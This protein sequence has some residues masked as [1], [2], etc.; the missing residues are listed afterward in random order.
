M[1]NGTERHRILVIDD[2]SIVAAAL[3]RLLEHDYDVETVDSAEE[4]LRLLQTTNF[5]VVVTDL[6]MRG[7]SGLE[8]IKS[9]HPEKPQL[10]VILLTGHHTTD[11]AI[12]AIKFGAFDYVLKPISSQREIQEFLALIAKAVATSVAA[13]KPAGESERKPPVNT[14]VGRSRQMQQVY[15]EI[16]RVAARPVLVLIRGET[17][18][19]KELVARA[20]HRYS[21]R[22]EQPFVIVNCV[23]IPEALL[24]S[25]LFGHEQGAFTGAQNTR[26][27]K[28]EQADKGTLFLDEIGD[29]SLA[30]QAK[31]LRVMQ[32]SAIRR[33][34]G[35][36]LIR[37]DVRVVAATHRDL[38]QA[39]AAKTFREDLYYRL[40]DASIRLPSLRERREDI[41]PLVQHFLHLHPGT[42]AAGQTTI[43]GDALR[44]LQY[45]SW[46][47]NV[48][49]L[50]N[51]VNQAA[52]MARGYAI[53][54]EIVRA[55]ME[56]A[57]LS[58]REP[59]Q[60]LDS[61][62]AELL[63]NA[64]SEGSTNVQ[65]ALTEWV[66]RELY[67]QAMR[68]AGEDQSQVARWL[69]V[70]RPTVRERL[71]HYGLHPGGQRV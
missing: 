14:M 45:H 6:Q 18:T 16:G 37:V 42:P 24:E 17:G 54:S 8:F 62:V 3:R 44:I 32:E 36:E 1:N 52:V 12:E 13:I 64:V 50:K 11:H 71:L 47:G 7:K 70:S 22:A 43:N 2:D 49:E 60:F 31:L 66:E 33:V 23:A 69:G 34:G 57:N 39:V 38:E 10:P 21:D 35:K 40:N 19:G 15:K 48:R 59:S 29:M 53:N 9:L 25:E 30:T 58:Q 27:G 65:D 61:Y 55:A 63:E 56:Q 51:V 28:F 20:I 46:P 68:L 26:V 4:G 5:D 41:P 67:G